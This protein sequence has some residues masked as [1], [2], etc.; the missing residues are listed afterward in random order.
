MLL[1]KITMNS[2]KLTKLG[3]R[4][5]IGVSTVI[6]FLVGWMMLA[7]SGKPA[8]AGVFA[9][10]PATDGQGNAIS[11]QSTVASL[12][13]I[14]SLSDLTGG[15]QAQVQSVQPQ[16]LP[17]LPRISGGSFPRMRSGGS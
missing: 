10:Q 14:P 1:E 4:L 7:H 12:P 16:P 3:L 11:S 15:A 13:P 5:W 6:G 2:M 17:V 8:P 9:A